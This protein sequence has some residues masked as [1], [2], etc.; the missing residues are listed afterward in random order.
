MTASVTASIPRRRWRRRDMRWVQSIE[1]RSSRLTGLQLRHWHP[2]WF[3]G[4]SPLP[5]RHL[6]LFL[7]IAGPLVPDAE[8]VFF[9]E[10]LGNLELPLLV[11]DGRVGMVHDQPVGPHPGA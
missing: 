3:G 2:D 10:Q 9:L 4:C 8:D 7:D 5:D 11:S 1:A 6:P